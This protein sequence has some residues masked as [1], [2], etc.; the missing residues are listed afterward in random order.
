MIFKIFKE[1]KN[2][3]PNW[4]P[5]CALLEI[6]NL[7]VFFNIDRIITI[8][9]NIIPCEWVPT[10]FN[11]SNNLHIKCNSIYE[12]IMSKCVLVI[13]DSQLTYKLQA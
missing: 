9:V 2:V 11:Q 3:G 12:S 13:I 4:G 1:N 8:I 5:S 6:A 7:H 10:V